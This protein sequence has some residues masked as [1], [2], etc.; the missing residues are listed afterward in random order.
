MTTLVHAGGT[1]LLQTS[2][3]TKDIRSK[4]VNVTTSA[5]HVQLKAK[6]VQQ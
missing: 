5:N 6:E 2:R 4:P 1:E 3:S